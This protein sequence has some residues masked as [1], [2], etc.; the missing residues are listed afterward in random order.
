MADTPK[1]PELQ[2][3]KPLWRVAKQRTEMHQRRYGKTWF[4]QL[5]L[6]LLREWSGT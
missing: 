4:E 3:V 1:T 5:E 6:M 2:V